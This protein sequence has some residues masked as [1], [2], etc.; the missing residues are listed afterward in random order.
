MTR[1]RR[2]IFL[3]VAATA[4]AC[5]DETSVEPGARSIVVHAVL[6]ASSRDQYII[7]QT[8]NG[9][10]TSQLPVAGAS[11]VIVTP[12]GRNLAAVEEHDS[13]F[14]PVR[15]GER[16][17]NSFYHV[18]LD[19]Y[20]VSLLSGS[21]YQLRVT[22]P[23]G[24]VVT[25]STTMPGSTPRASLNLPQTLTR[26]VESLSLAWPRVAGAS[27]YDVSI[28]STRTTYQA[29]TDTAIVVPGTARTSDGTDAFIPGIA[30]VVVSA[31]D[32]NYYDYYRR[33]SDILTGAG[34]ISHLQGG[35][36]VFGSIVPLG[37]GTV[38][39]R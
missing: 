35:I 24:R 26:A 20:G 15:S 10:V 30:H 29:F 14:Y 1:L 27:A 17:V 2:F 21:T 6:D 36:G 13:T 16:L 12:D 28:S 25:G 37:S 18:S 8:T 22:L 19:R 33:G 23:D 3:A 38:V 4:A 39:V 5:V 9:A 7:V 32:A 34:P 31:V 11:V